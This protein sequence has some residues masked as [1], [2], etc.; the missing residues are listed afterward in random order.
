MSPSESEPARDHDE[1][2]V[3]KEMPATEESGLSS[4]D[5]GW[6]CTRYPDCN[7]IAPPRKVISHF[8]GRNKICTLLFPQCA[9]LW[10]CRK[11]YQRCRYRD[12]E[13]TE[14]T[15][16][17]Y[18]V[19]Q[20]KKFDEWSVQ[21]QKDGKTPFIIDWTVAL[22]KREQERLDAASGRKRA[23]PGSGAQVQEE[24]FPQWL[25]DRLGA[26]RS[27]EE[28][29]QIA[30]RIRDDLMANRL[31][32]LPEIEFLVNMQLGEGESDGRP[33]AKPRRRNGLLTTRNPVAKDDPL[34]HTVSPALE[35]IRQANRDLLPT[36]ED[37]PSNWRERRDEGNTRVPR[38]AGFSVPSHLRI[39]QQYA[40]FD[41]GSTEPA[42]SNGRQAST[43][44]DTVDTSAAQ[45]TS[46]MEHTSS[47]DG[48]TA[49]HQ[50]TTTQDFGGSNGHASFL[51]QRAAESTSPIGHLSAGGRPTAVNQESQ[52]YATAPQQLRQGSLSEM[53]SGMFR[54]T[55]L[56]G[57][58]PYIPIDE[59]YSQDFAPP[60]PRGLYHGG[61]GSF[62][63][64][65]NG[66][67]STPA[68]QVN[69]A[70][71][72]FSTAPSHSVDSSVNGTSFASSGSLPS[73][74]SPFHG[75]TR[76][77]SS[78]LAASQLPTHPYLL[79]TVRQGD[80]MQVVRQADQTERSSVT[81]RGY[82]TDQW[83]EQ[84]QIPSEDGGFIYPPL[85]GQ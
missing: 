82:S 65:V 63:A 31:T 83:T 81:G 27:T 66:I 12:K 84:A 17:D 23:E 39:Q 34:L 20:L 19:R 22:R 60:G 10:C 57:G 40:H 80:Q 7:L 26:G 54:Q 33:K 53:G 61:P 29:L 48:P 50:E 25:L 77:Q 56:G 44:H 46:P 24:D 16:M 32:K 76:R 13:N 73:T 37:H 2:H 70:Y 64:Q 36:G 28:S 6:I 68:T 43:N 11:H 18:V 71:Y 62:S 74:G 55:A 38:V 72:G 5:F 4:S 47:P 21:Q 8:F 59:T 51:S 3:K 67:H 14:V 35:I 45:S 42:H 58:V 85:P 9:W 30:T 41:M 75:H 49:V 1:D 69:Q 78:H 15:Q 52:R 79:Q